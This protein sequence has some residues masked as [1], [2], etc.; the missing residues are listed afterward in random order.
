MD[1]GVSW[2]KSAEDWTPGGSGSGWLGMET[3][4]VVPD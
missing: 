3:A 4:H 2:Q 1:G